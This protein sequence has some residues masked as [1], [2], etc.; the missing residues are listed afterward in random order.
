MEPFN[1][2]WTFIGDRQYP[3][4]DNIQIQICW[5]HKTNYDASTLVHHDI[6]DRSIDRPPDHPI[7][8]YSLETSCIQVS[9]ILV[10]PLKYQYHPN[11]VIP[12]NTL[13]GS[14]ILVNIDHCDLET[15]SLRPVVSDIKPVVSDLY[16]I[17]RLPGG[18]GGGDKT[19]SLGLRQSKTGRRQKLFPNM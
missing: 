18:G 4:S 11:G 13:C 16:L 2:K 9:P 1:C 15:W 8:L 7:C 19:A 14:H 5:S 3:N 17:F 12:A 10:S 6:L